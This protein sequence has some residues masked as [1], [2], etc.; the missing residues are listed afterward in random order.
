MNASILFAVGA[1]NI[2]PIFYSAKSKTSLNFSL[3]IS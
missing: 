2:R 3:K 1:D